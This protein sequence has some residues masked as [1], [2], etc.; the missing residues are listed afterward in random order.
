[1]LLPSGNSAAPIKHLEA[2]AKDYEKR[3]MPPPPE[4]TEYYQLTCPEELYH[5]YLDFLELSKRRGF[6][7]AGPIPLTWLD[8]QAW[9]TLRGVTLMQVEIDIL[10][11]IDEVWIGIYRK[12]NTKKA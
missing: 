7:E 11:M 5:I 9:S 8:L 2:V 1:M 6:V 12:K 4:L 3:G 10:T